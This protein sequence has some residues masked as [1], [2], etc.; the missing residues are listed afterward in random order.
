MHLCS[1]KYTK[2]HVALNIGA[3]V[4]MEPFCQLEAMAH[5]LL[6]ET[7]QTVVGL[8]EVQI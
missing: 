8:G 6:L 7:L 2:L 3:T 4:T 1:L 5:P